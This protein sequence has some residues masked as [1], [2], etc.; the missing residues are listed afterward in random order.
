MNKISVD[1]MSFRDEYGRERIFHGINY[2]SK[3]YLITDAYNKKKP[4]RQ[5]RNQSDLQ[6]GNEC[7]KVFRQLVVS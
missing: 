6:Y 3:N 1:A 2:G 5:R 4:G 7:G